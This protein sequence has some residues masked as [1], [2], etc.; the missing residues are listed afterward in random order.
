LLFPKL[1][2]VTTIDFFVEVMDT[3]FVQGNQNIM[4]LLTAYKKEICIDDKYIETKK[5]SN[6]LC[7]F[8]VGKVHKI[9][10]IYFHKNDQRSWIV[11]FHPLEPI[12]EV[13]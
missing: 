8:W 10:P 6:Y 5:D 4:Q 2:G 13:Y 1:S 11:D 7:L 3:K 12:L 9:K